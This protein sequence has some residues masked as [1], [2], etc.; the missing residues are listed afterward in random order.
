M[1]WM[2]R[3]S[4]S[5]SLLL[6]L[7]GCWD[8]AE[9]PEKGFVMGLAID[10]NEKGKFLLTAQIFKPVQAV[11]G[12]G[13]QMSYL[14]IMGEDYSIAKAIRD[15]PSRLGRKMQWSH[16][17][18]VIISEALARDKGLSDLMEFFYRDHEPRII[19]PVMIT[20]G[21]ASDVLRRKPLIENTLSQQLFEGQRA[22]AA[23]NAKTLDMN[24]LLLGKM[25][26]S[27]VGN[28]MIPYVF[29]SEIDGT[30]VLNIEGAALLK[31]GT[32]T[33][34]LDGEK[35]EGV[36]ML[37]NKYGSGMVKIP[38]GKG[39]DPMMN[40]SVEVLSLHSSMKPEFSRRPPVIRYAVKVQAAIVELTCSRKAETEDEAKA[41]ADRAGMVIKRK[42]EGATG[43]LKKIKF[44]ALGLGNV[45]YRKDPSLWKQW[46]PE[47][48]DL[49]AET[50]FQFDV[51]VTLR[52]SGTNVGH[53]ALHTK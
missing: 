22:S 39:E 45:L 16:L 28:S 20:Q 36:Q 27:E 17:R 12:K 25:T 43:Y 41:F 10:E 44:D 30:P 1:N 21:R 37:L 31:K 13:N 19:A 32:M 51:E 46:K 15:I 29:Q 14:H 33:G 8:Q 49:F 7:T 5:F 34:R 52:S 2:R 40:E 4:V 11:G 24:L 48:D 26:R 35:M 6:L 47:W 50:S 18:V 38:C 23:H 3:I 9:L 53:S 42:L